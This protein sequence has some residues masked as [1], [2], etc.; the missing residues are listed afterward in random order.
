MIHLFLVGIDHTTAPVALRE[1]L[2]FSAEE[3]VQALKQLTYADGGVLRE[4]V[5]LSTCNRVEVYGVGKDADG[6]EAMQRFLAAFH[7]LPY[8]EVAPFMIVRRG[9]EVA[10]HLCAT[11]AGLHSIVLGEAQI[12]GQV[13]NAVEVAQRE[14]ASGSLLNGLFRHALAAGKRVRHETALGKGAASV[15]QAG[16]ELARRQLGGLRGKRVLLVGSGTMSE[17]AVKNLQAYGA[18]DLM[19]TNRTAA[20]AEALAERYGACAIPFDALDE[21]LGAVD[22]LISATSSPEPVIG[23]AA[24]TAALNARRAHHDEHHHPLLLLDLAVPRDIDPAVAELDGVRLATVDDLQGLVDATLAQRR[25]E[26]APAQTIVAEEVAAFERWL[27]E[28]E[29][30]P[31][32]TSLRQQAEA[33]RQTELQRAMRRLGELS[34]EQQQA[35][36]VLTQSLV[37]KL[38]HAPTLRLKD[39]AAAGDGSRYAALM[40]E[41]F[42]LE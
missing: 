23:K 38:L 3:V 31:A 6:L 20:K 14:H 37:N 11:A 10:A 28:Q 42:A 19:I 33:L 7:A 18:T 26:L 24:V 8:A 13:R 29:T 36:D 4:A 34:P 40:R 17:L 30:L 12:Q 39:A 9:I 22:I 2:S 1:R 5:I 35:V 16:V 21:V 32:L 27:R 15:S 25:N 41:L